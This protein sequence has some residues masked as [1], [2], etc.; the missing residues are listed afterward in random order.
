[1]GCRWTRRGFHA[2]DAFAF[3][4]DA[5][6]R[7]ERWDI[8]VSDPPSF[9]PRKEACPRRARRISGCTGWRRPVVA[10]GG[11]LCAASCSSHFGKDEFLRSIEAGAR[12]AGRRW[13]FG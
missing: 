10:P 13:E 7:G 3:L 1:M 5:G 4:E 8:V 6:E 11:L 2:G 12:Q 9:A